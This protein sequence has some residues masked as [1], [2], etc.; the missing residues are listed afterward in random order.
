MTGRV[1]CYR[2]RLQRGIVRTECGDELAFETSGDAEAI[3]GDDLVEFVFVDQGAEK[4]ARV[5]RIVETAVSRSAQFESL[6]HELFGNVDSN[7][8]PSK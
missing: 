5:T 6:L 2:P 1:V 8:T 3:Q 4:T 7:R